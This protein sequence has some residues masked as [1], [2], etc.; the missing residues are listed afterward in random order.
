MMGNVQSGK[1]LNFIGLLNKALDVGYH[2]IIVLGGHMNEL[3]AQA[4]DRIDAGVIHMFTTVKTRCT[5]VSP[6]TC[7]HH[8]RERFLCEYCAEYIAELGS[9]SYRVRGEKA[10][11]NNGRIGRLVY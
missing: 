5:L 4:Q 6:A 2:T 1:T 3:R 11:G 7:T 8:Q 10:S 9:H